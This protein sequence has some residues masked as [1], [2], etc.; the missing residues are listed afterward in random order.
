MKK[1]S[2][3]FIAF[4]LTLSV[5]ILSSCNDGD[6]PTPTVAPTITVTPDDDTLK[7]TVG[8]IVDYQVNWSSTDPL[9]S[10]KISYTAGTLSQIILD[11]TFATEVKSFGFNLSIE[12]TDAIPVGT[13]IE[14][15]YFGST[16]DNSTLISRYVLVETGMSTYEGV[17]L[18][19]QA[20]G[21]ATAATNLS[22]YFSAMNERFTLNQS[23]DADTSAL[24]DLVFTHHA[25]FR[26]NEELS[27]QS[28]NSAN[29]HQMWA[30]LPGF[31]PP[32]DY[33]IDNKN[34]TYFKKVDVADWDNLDYDGIEEVVGD[35]GTEIKIRG[36]FE[37]DFIAFETQAGKKGIM[38]I[39]TTVIEHNPYNETYITFDVKVQK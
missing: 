6:N 16:K 15:I 4:T 29:L 12:V 18:Q 21:P 27:F 22:F 37:G 8:E 17:V 39:I 38:K 3:L 10:A 36:I 7:V 30:E 23:A 31:D 34:Q 14:F 28:P 26:T 24:I 9:Q 11:T 13:V 20:D 25:I 5:S 35:I 2:L 19:A 1:L 33:N 32:Y